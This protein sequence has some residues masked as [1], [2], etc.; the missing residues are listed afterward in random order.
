[1]LKNAFFVQ[2]TCTLYATADRLKNKLDK[3]FPLR[4][5]LCAS[6]EG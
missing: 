3:Q 5:R 2:I 4:H 6:A 1:V